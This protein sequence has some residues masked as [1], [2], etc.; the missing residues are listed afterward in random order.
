[1]I[2]EHDPVVL[3]SIISA[4]E[5]FFEK[6]EL[7]FVMSIIN[8]ILILIITYVIIG[9]IKRFMKLNTKLRLHH[10]NTDKVK[11]IQTANTVIVS[12]S[13]YMLWFVAVCLCIG[14]LGLG[15]TMKSLLV[16][17]GIGGI[18]IGF[19]AQN[20]IKDV[21]AGLFMLFEDQLAVGDFVTIGEITGT[22]D[23]IG[24]RSTGIQ[25]FRGELNIIPNG[26]INTITNYS[27][28]DYLAIIYVNIAHKADAQRAL[29]LMQEEASLLAA[30]DSS[31]LDA[32][33]RTAVTEIK[34]NAVTLRLMLTVKPM[35]HWA[36]QN[37][38]HLRINSRFEKEG[39]EMPYTKVFILNNRETY[40]NRF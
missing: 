25:G 15:N 39:I 10:A 40:D 34:D 22:V 26:S 8:I 2:S 18:A 14:E 17:A 23:S 12:V 21:L 31:I 3:T 4:M 19:G 28:S 37:A 30:L 11:R 6:Y 24:L 35:Q 32:P 29:R 9:F 38:M 16:T 1:M 33:G 36:V 27:R 20:L 13:R 7:G 5:T